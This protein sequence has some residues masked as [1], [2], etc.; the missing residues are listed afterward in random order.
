MKKKTAKADKSIFNRRIWERQRQCV[1]WRAR[2]SAQHDYQ[3]H[4]K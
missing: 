2:E 4:K 3:K 1:I